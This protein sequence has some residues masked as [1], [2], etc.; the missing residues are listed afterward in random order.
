MMDIYEGDFK[1][2]L[3]DLENTLL[4]KKTVDQCNSDEEF[5]MIF[6]YL[7]LFFDYYRGADNLID[8]KITPAVFP[9]VRSAA[10]CFVSI[11]GL[12]SKYG[13]VDFEIEQNQIYYENARQLTSLYDATS[14][15]KEKSEL[16]DRTKR[17]LEVTGDIQK[18]DNKSYDECKTILKQKKCSK[19]KTDLIYETFS[20]LP[21]YYNSDIHSCETLYGELCVYTHNNSDSIIQRYY[22]IRNNPPIFTQNKID[23]NIIPAK[24]MFV[25][26]SRYINS[27]VKTNIIA[28]SDE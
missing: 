15:Q 6:Q 24:F 3:K 17:I 5:R 12:C 1:S 2:T 16:L 27:W 21:E 22:D 9:I 7:F 14:D 8:N 23:D 11:Y 10:E 4:C 20:K 25:A 18:S 28:Q 19:R 26:C 13:T